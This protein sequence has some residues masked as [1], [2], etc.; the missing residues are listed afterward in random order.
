MSFKGGRTMKRALFWDVGL[1]ATAISASAPPAF[2]QVPEPA[3]SL[4]DSYFTSP[5]YPDPAPFALP[6]R[7]TSSNSSTI[8]KGSVGR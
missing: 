2:G 3:L 6:R 8:G 7:T 5:R 4:R 1:A